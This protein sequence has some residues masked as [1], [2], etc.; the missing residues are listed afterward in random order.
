MIAQDALEVVS[1]DRANGF[2]ERRF[3]TAE[4]VLDLPVIGACMN[5][6]EIYRGTGLL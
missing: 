3:E 6:R 2:A 1:F 5:L 4:S